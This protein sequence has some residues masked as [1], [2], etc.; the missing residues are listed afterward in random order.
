MTVRIYAR[1]FLIGLLSLGPAAAE[2]GTM[3]ATGDAVVPPTGFI[4]FCV[5]HGQEC[6]VN[7]AN[8]APVELTA[9]R[10]AELDRVQAD[11]NWQIKPREEPTHQWKYASDGYGDCNT[12]ALTKRRTLIAMGW[13]E[14]DLLLAAVKDELGEGHL[15][16]VARTT[17][18]DLVLDNRLRP[19]ID[20]A[21]LPYHW[22]SMQSQKSAARWLRV[23]GQ[24]VVVAAARPV[25]S[26]SQAHP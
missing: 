12:Y 17:G 6:L 1:L 16:L 19:V 4:A 13:P 22:I 15:V 5:Q 3:I 9:A 7:A 11:V 18:G 8:P 20:W 25:G 23:T 14:E 21:S 2:A 26:D 24:P 10:R